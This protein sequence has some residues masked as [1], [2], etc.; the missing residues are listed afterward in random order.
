MAVIGARRLRIWE[1]ALLL[2]FWED[3]EALYK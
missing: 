1:A 2:F 3:K